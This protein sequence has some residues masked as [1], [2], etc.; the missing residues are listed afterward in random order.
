[1]CV[2]RDVGVGG[3]ARAR[4]C[5][6][7]RRFIT[8]TLEFSYFKHPSETSEAGTRLRRR[9]C[10]CDARLLLPALKPSHRY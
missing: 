2:K 10:L 3:A 8:L 4:A 9:Q 5:H 7:N 1:M 6:L